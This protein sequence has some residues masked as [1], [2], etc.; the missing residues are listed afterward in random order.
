MCQEDEESYN[1]DIGGYMH[2]LGQEIISSPL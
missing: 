2:A 1:E